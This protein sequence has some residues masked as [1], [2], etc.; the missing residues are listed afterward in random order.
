MKVYLR[1]HPERLTN[2]DLDLAHELPR[3]IRKRA[4][5]LLLS[6]GFGYARNYS[7]QRPL[8]VSLRMADDPAALGCVLDVVRNA[9]V[10]GNDL[11]QAVVVAVEREA[12]DDV[13]YPPDS[14][15]PFAR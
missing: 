12:G 1:I 9:Q 6:H 13:V 11:S 4:G 15:G 5:D 14:Q 8:L 2:P 7:G 3:E 10:L